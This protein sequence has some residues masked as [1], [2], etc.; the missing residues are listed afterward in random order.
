MARCLPSALNAVVRT[1]RGNVP[2]NTVF[3][4][5]TLRTWSWLSQPPVATSVPS[6]L[7]ATV[8]TPSLCPV[9]RNASFLT[10]AGGSPIFGTGLGISQ[11]RAVRSWP[12]DTS[13][14]PS[15]DPSAE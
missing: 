5:A 9:N 10:A 3:L 4:S 13:S 1:R 2:E 15:A 7:N 6:G 8:S 14:F 11:S 12:P